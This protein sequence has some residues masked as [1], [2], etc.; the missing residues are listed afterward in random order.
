MGIVYVLMAAGLN[1]VWGVMKVINL[2]HGSFLM[3]GAYTAYWLFVW[4]GFDPLLSIPFVL[5]LTFGLGLIVWRVVVRRFQRMEYGG[6]AENAQ[7]MALYGL[8][9]A[10]VS[11]TTYVWGASLVGIPVTYAS[12]PFTLIGGI[13]VPFGWVIAS[14]F[15]LA[16][17]L[18]LLVLLYHTTF[19][20][21]VRATSQDVAEAELSGINTSRVA[22]LTFGLGTCLAG[23]GG[24]LLPL[25]SPGISTQI[26]LPYTILT[27]AVIIIGGLGEPLGVIIG[28]IIF[29]IL[30]SVVSSLS[31]A[32]TQIV[33]F[34]CVIIILYFKPRGLLPPKYR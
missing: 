27:F 26:A 11:M 3:I 30:Q 28:G 10:V 22:A 4:F 13:V 29:G 14:S 5:P 8:S 21:E 25:V 24:S 23:I 34:L 18:G 12:L 9:Y 15:S 7:F 6:P 20:K 17:T 1:L 2:A 16:F 32:L 31:P 19:G 33:G